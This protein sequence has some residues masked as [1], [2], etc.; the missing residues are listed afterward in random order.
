MS[1]RLYG[2]EVKRTLRFQLGELVRDR[3]RN[4]LLLTA[5]PHNGSNE[6]FLL[7]MSLLDPDRFAGRLRN[8]PQ[9]PDVS[10]V[11]RRYVKENLLTFE[12]KRLFP[13][14]QATTVN[15]DLSPDEERLYEAVSSYVQDGMGRAQALEAGRRPA[16]RPRGRLRA[17][18][19]AAPARVVT[20]GDLPVA[21]TPPRAANQSARSRPTVPGA[22]R[23]RNASA[24]ASPTPTGS[25]PT[26]STTTSSSGS[27][28][29]RSRTR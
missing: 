9:V 21:A 7:F 4:L 27:R 15:Y 17:R 8:T 3:T 18:R 22:S 1:A 20:G 5:T 14:R 11:M 23:R 2:D 19:A 26:T 13:E 29:R 12:G 28:T 16:A 10:D 24:A 6:D 25:T